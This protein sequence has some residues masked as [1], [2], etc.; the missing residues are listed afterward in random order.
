MRSCPVGSGVAF[1]PMRT[2]AAV[3]GRFVAGLAG[4][5]LA[6]G[7]AAGAAASV[8]ASPNEDRIES[9]DIVPE[10]PNPAYDQ[11]LDYS[12][13]QAEA[14][15]IRIDL[16]ESGAA[17]ITETIT[18]DFTS[19][20]RRGIFRNFVVR[21]EIDDERDRVYPVRVLDVSSPD[22]PDDWTIE[23][24][25]PTLTV[26]I[27][28][29]ERYAPRVATYTIRYRVEGAVDYF[30]DNPAVEDHDEFYWNVTGH[31]WDVPRAAVTVRVTAP[32]APDDVLCFAGAHGAATQCSSAAVSEGAAD[33]R[34]GWLDPREGLTIAVSYPTGTF[35]GSG[36]VIDDK[37]SAEETFGLSAPLA[38][39]V[40]GATLIGGALVAVM[41]WLVGRDRQGSSMAVD[42]AFSESTEGGS[43]VRL[44]ELR[45]VPVEFVPP[46]KVRPGHFGVL[47]DEIADDRDVI[48]T[49]VDLA[50]RGHLIIEDDSTSDTDVDITLRRTG[51]DDSELTRHEHELVADLFGHSDE[52]HM[53]GPNARMAKA[54]TKGRRR[55]YRDMADEGWFGRDPF[56]NRG[57]WTT[58]GGAIGVSGVALLALLT[59]IGRWALAAVPVILA[60]ALMIGAARLMPARTPRG[61]GLLRRSLGFR[62]FLVDS[63][64]VRARWAEDNSI[65][66]QY[67]PYVIALGETDKWADT[68]KDLKGAEQPD[69]YRSRHGWNSFDFIY[70]G[71]HMGRT[72]SVPVQS[73][74]GSRGGWNPGGGF[75][76]GAF[77]GGGFSGGGGFGGGGGSW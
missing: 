45:N 12:G 18:W 76:G 20:F 64:A 21:Q 77:G 4:L 66:T 48:A 6:G 8:H 22:A 53:D 24:D 5:S 65:L 33:F 41:T 36:P 54:I 27:G 58:L 29:P 61:T 14:F 15:D 60:G 73:N 30:R 44:F 67:L 16:D 23:G 47:I 52:L 74:A 13:E 37:W 39:G 9:V 1:P 68:F 69:W 62:K 70:L 28:N 25:D 19:D 71:H 32:G 17:V 34:Q 35:D 38:A 2:W 51:A 49:I 7:F 57:T 10:A 56:V 75:G 31:Q 40:G 42:A 46:D 72:A 43:R 63:E 55:L 11:P 3:I 26:R 50:V 59:F